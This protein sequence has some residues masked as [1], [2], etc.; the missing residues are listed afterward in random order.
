METKTV[1]LYSLDYSN[2]KTYLI[3]ALFIAGNMALPQLFHLIPQGG[4][5]WLPIYFFTLI[6]AY[7]FGWKV[8]LLTAVLSPI[9]N[10]LLFGMP[11]PAVLPAILLKSV[12]LAI[13]AG[14]AAHR[15][16]RI[17]LP[18]LL[19]VVLFYQDSR[20]FSRMGHGW[21]FLPSCT[22]FPHRPAGNGNAGSR[23]IC[24]DQ[25]QC[26]SVIPQIRLIV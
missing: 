17:S 25:I 7:K 13:A 21:Q 24:I 4:I 22:G 5:T 3:A 11:L 9:A 15:F 26:V 19:A 6:G 20:Y 12:L 1:K 18:I 8:G 23:R 16:N 10:A 14:W 2:V